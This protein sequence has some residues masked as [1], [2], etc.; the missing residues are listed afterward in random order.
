MTFMTFSRLF[1]SHL[2]E[3]PGKPEDYLITADADLW[4]LK[5]SVVNMP[6]EFELL[7]AH[8]HCCGT[9]EHRGREYRMLPMSYIGARVSTWRQIMDFSSTLDKNQSEEML[10]Y[11]EA[12]FG[13][14]VH[15]PN[16]KRDS[17]QWYYDQYMISLKI[18]NWISKYGNEKV[19]EVSEET[20]DRMDRT[21]WEYFPFYSDSR[22]QFNSY[23]DAH[24]PLT[25]YKAIPWM[26]FQV[27]LRL[28]YGNKSREKVRWANKYATLY[29]KKM[30]KLRLI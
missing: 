11:F 8:S 12:E 18:D 29:H 6:D 3:F 21:K 16:V 28:M 19:L 23:D 1:A 30:V 5:A 10:K 24:L 14:R 15:A 25:G 4:P 13:P 9:F 20:F 17:N 27:L 22:K 2:L 26:S 7:L